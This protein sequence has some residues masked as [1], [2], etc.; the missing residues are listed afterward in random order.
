MPRYNAAPPF[1]RGAVLRVTIV[2]AGLLYPIDGPLPR[3]RKYDLLSAVQFV[4]TGT[5]HSESGVQV[6]PFPTDLPAL[7]NPCSS[8]AGSYGTKDEGTPTVVVNFGGFTAYL[9]ISCTTRGIGDDAA[10][11]NRAR[12]AFAA[13][14]SYAVELQLSRDYAVIGNPHLTQGGLTAL[15]AGAVTPYE[16]LAL[17]ENSIAAETAIEGL[18]HADPATVTAWA[19]DVLVVDDGGVLVTVAN[20]TRVVSGAG[21]VGIH[22]ADEAAPGTS[23]AWVFATGPVQV[24]RSEMYVIPETIEEAVDRTFNDV[25]YRAERNYVVD[26][27]AAYLAEVLADRSL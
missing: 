7:H 4:D 9:P 3:R 13:K 16:A 23:Q 10:F 14:E 18:I 27:D 12:V 26:W 22:P 19:K 25:T 2:P 20:G 21:Y 17:I 15:G 5:V 24:L 11:V 6:Y 8:G 1:Y